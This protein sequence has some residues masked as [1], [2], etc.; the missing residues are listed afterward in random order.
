MVELA[1][2]NVQNDETYYFGQEDGQEFAQVDFWELYELF[3]VVKAI[4][5]A[6]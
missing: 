6:N 1:K 2:K 4:Q 5:L 3:K